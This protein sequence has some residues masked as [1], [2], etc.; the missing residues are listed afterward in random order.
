MK[1]SLG[2]IERIIAWTGAE[3]PSEERPKGCGQP[4]VIVT[5]TGLAWPK[6]TELRSALY[7]VYS[8]GTR[9]ELME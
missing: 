8:R 1:I 4:G 3:K 2:Q 6:D 9:T 5:P 7:L